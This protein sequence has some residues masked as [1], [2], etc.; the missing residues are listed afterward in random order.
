M[1]LAGVRSLGTQAAI[2]AITSDHCD[3]VVNN[4]EFITVLEGKTKDGMIIH[5]ATACR[6]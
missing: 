6:P 1:I 3:M 2:F 4:E 5:I